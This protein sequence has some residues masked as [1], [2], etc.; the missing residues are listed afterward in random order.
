MLNPRLGKTAMQ[1]IRETHPTLRRI[2]GWSRLELADHSSAAGRIV[3]LDS[4]NERVAR[5][6]I[7]RELYDDV[8][9]RLP[10]GFGIYVPQAYC[11]A[12]VIVENPQGIAYLD[13]TPHA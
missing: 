6:C 7:S 11:L 2:I 1:T 3:A 9:Q 12:G 4:T 8:P 5:M 13:A 10:D